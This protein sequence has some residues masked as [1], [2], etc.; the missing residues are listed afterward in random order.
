M[1][2]LYCYHFLF[3][4][5]TFHIAIIRPHL[6]SPPL[7]PAFFFKT[8][9][10][11]SYAETSYVI[12][13]PNPPTLVSTNHNCLGYSVPHRVILHLYVSPLI[14]LAKTNTDINTKKTTLLYL[15]LLPFFE[16]LISY[17]LFFFP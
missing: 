8:V 4:I 5:P 7:P 11:C 13:T 15:K 14:L 6:L 2:K 17:F 1:I 9:P 16:T 10:L 12:Q 3:S